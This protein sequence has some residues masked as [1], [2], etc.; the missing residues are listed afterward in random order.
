[1]N[2]THKPEWAERFD[3]WFIEYVPVEWGAPPKAW[4][5]QFT[6]E[7]LPERLD[8]KAF[9]SQEIQRAKGPYEE[10]IFAVGNKYPGETRHQTAL[11]YIKQAETSTNSHATASSP[12]SNKTSEV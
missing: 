6:G 5:A 7:T 3:K 2:D 1:M 8:I 12:D 9:L 11:R 4:K 10:L